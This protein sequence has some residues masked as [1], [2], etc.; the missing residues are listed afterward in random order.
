MLAAILLLVRPPA[1]PFA[2]PLLAL[3]AVLAALWA[4]ELHRFS[5]I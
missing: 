5:F 3:V 4:F 1:R 2:V